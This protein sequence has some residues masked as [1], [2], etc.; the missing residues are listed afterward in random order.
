MTVA[1]VR[2]GQYT[3]RYDFATGQSTTVQGA[4]QV[5]QRQLILRSNYGGTEVDGF[6]LRGRIL[7]VDVQNFGRIRLIKQ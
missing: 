2:S 3:I 1:L 5:Q 4:W 6:Q 7:D